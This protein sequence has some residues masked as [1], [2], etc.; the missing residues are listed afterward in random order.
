MSFS[1][2]AK[3]KI[4]K[5]YED[6]TALRELERDLGIDRKDLREWIRRYR[7]YGDDGLKRKPHA[8]STY[9]MRCEAVRAIAEEGVTYS[10]I[11]SRYDV[12]RHI[13]KKWV[14]KYRAEGYEALKSKMNSKINDRKDGVCRNST[15]LCPDV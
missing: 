12:S 8:R 11:V 5:M 6:G 2:K 9:E 15:A 7:L 3:I 1:R 14:A 13:L 4:V 10:E